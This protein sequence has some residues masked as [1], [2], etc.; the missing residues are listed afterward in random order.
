MNETET[1]RHGGNAP[2]ATRRVSLQ[3]ETDTKSAGAWRDTTLGTFAAELRR[4]R[5]A[6]ERGVRWTITWLHERAGTMNDGHARGILNSAA[7][8]LGNELA[9]Q[10]DG[11]KSG[12]ASPESRSLPNADDAA[13]QE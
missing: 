1:N 11:R 9:R 2:D 3:N 12:V 6:Y 13:S 10:V 8:D 7:H 5:L 4:R